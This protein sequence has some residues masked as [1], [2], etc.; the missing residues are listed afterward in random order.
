MKE[1]K[2]TKGLSYQPGMKFKKPVNFRN[3]MIIPD[4]LNKWKNLFVELIKNEFYKENKVFVLDDNNREK[5]A[6]CF[7]WVI[8]DVDVTLNKGLLLRGEVGTGKSSI[9]K[10]CKRLCE[11]IYNNANGFLH[12]IYI[13]A[14]EVSRLYKE[15][16]EETEKRLTQIMTSRLL[17]IDDIGYEALKV[18]DH[19]P[20]SEVIRERYDK[21]RVTCFTTNLSMDAIRERYKT[22][23]EDKLSEMCFI[24]KFDGESKRV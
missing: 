12:P 11:I 22:S 3:A 7:K 9:M 21:K 1:I 14:D 8:G 15:S 17:F 19:Y 5:I 20:I 4:E 2:L 6:F 13:T 24:V 10:A 23:I 16:S 18:Y